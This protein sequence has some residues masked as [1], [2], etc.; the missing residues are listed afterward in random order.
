MCDSNVDL[1]GDGVDDIIDNC[2]NV[3]NP[4]QL[5]TDLD[6]SGDACDLDDDNDGIP[7]ICINPLSCL[8]DNCPLFYNPDQLDS[9]GTYSVCSD[10]ASVFCLL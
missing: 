10:R 8:P 7:D 2:P 1:D 6:G 4:S 3:I 5:D 9:N